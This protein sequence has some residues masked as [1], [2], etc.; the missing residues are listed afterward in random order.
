MEKQCRK[1]KQVKPVSDFRQDKAKRDKLQSWCKQCHSTNTTEWRRKWL[2]KRGM[3][4][5]DYNRIRRFGI[6]PEVYNAMLKTQNHVCAICK[7][8]ETATGK[9]GVKPLCVDHC[10]K[11]GKN[12]ALLCNACNV[13]LG[14]AKD[15]IETLT[16]AIKYLNT[17]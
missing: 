9:L 13:L 1:C 12:R 14:A 5:T 17:Y 11:T 16:A 4:Y 15:K 3:T 7:Q 2:A 10:H 8:P 6:T